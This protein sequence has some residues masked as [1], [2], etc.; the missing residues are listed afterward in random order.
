MATRY[1]FV[2]LI[3]S[4]SYLPGALTLAAALRD[5]HPKPAV[6]PEVD[7]QTACLV[8][9]ETV[10]VSSI[11]LLRG[12]FDVVIGVEVIDDEDRKGLELLGR[13][14]LA[15]ALTKLHAFRLAQ[16]TKVIYLDSDVL[17]IRPISHLFN[18]EHEF[19]AV[20]DVGWPD[21]FNSGVMV[22][23][24]GEE[25]FKAITDL[26]KEKGSWDGADQGLLNEWRGSNWNRLSFTYNTTPTAAYTYA[27]AYERFG[28][29]ISAIH[30]IG[31]NKPWYSILSRPPGA[32]YSL[33]KQTEGERVYD[34]DSLVDRWYSVY[35]RHYRSDS[36]PTNPFEVQQYD[37][38]WNQDGDFGAGFRTTASFNLEELRKIAVNGW[39]RLSS[40]SINRSG[41]GEYLSMPLE[42]R[43][44]LMRPKKH[45]LHV[46]E[47]VVSADTTPK[48]AHID[49]DTPSTPRAR[50]PVQ[51]TTLPTPSPSQV[52]PA[53][54]RLPLSLPPSPFPPG[55]QQSQPQTKSGH[56]LVSPPQYGAP[57]S[58][59]FDEFD[60]HAADA[61]EPHW[62]H[63]PN[64]QHR[65]HISQRQRHSFH[66]ANRRQ[67]A[68]VGDE[69]FRPTNLLTVF[70]Q[71]DDDGQSSE[72]DGANREEPFMLRRR[73]HGAVSPT[74]VTWNPAV[75]PPPRT[76]PVLSSA[77]PE[78]YYPN[79]WDKVPSKV[80]DA[81]HHRYANVS[82]STSDS[83]SSTP[84]P[85]FELPIP[86]KIPEGLVREGHYLNVTGPTNGQENSPTPDRSKVAPIF[87]WEEKPR[88][89]PG[90]VF[91]S[92][93]T[94]P[95]GDFLVQK[96]GSPVIHFSGDLPGSLPGFGS[97]GSPPINIPVSL[98]YRN[99][100][101]VEPSIQKYASKLAR[102]E[103]NAPRGSLLFQNEEWKQHEKDKFSPWQPKEEETSMDG[104]DE[105]DSDDAGPPRHS[106]Q[107]SR[108]G[109][110]TITPQ[111]SLFTYKGKYRGRGVQTESPEHRSKGVQIT[112][113][114]Q[115][116]EYPA[117]TSSPRVTS[118]SGNRSR[119]FSY[120]ESPFSSLHSRHVSTADSPPLVRSPHV[121]ISPRKYSPPLVNTPPFLSPKYS[122]VQTPRR[123]SDTSSPVRQRV[124][125][126]LTT[127]IRSV[128]ALAR[129]ASN[130][131]ALS[132]SV[133]PPSPD[134]AST[135]VRSTR[136]WDPA[137]GVDIFKKGSEE[138]L[139]RFLRMGSFED[140]S[141]TPPQSR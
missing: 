139:S 43:I 135:P 79:I 27:P 138:V 58:D 118:L 125:S 92:T 45:S 77:L 134:I 19:S 84:G 32:L 109:S 117:H 36:I 17:P 99:A 70:N 71:A 14:D 102:P 26:L 9:P 46:P 55:S 16:F 83:G 47:I 7:F 140:G 38:I 104:D 4:D 8:T 121:L 110:G 22:F 12:A 52:P 21:I 78:T 103:Q 68:G 64:R 87:P 95:P 75:E 24:P 13:P 141:A 72:G 136:V 51:M 40:T 73:R 2:T 56:F 39:S 1:A 123:R 66:D 44:D 74:V 122:P 88:I 11:K 6:K 86:A 18:L 116:G 132:S 91:P 119:R 37:S 69:N 126:P 89:V 67:D 65:H 25:K 98:T 81:I 60:T 10:D 63:H 107:R 129:S 30:F 59:Q 112:P 35:D 108:A 80:H 111:G 131:T 76:R 137:R 93:D 105:D 62:P 20:P 127:S 82:V 90:R 23:S 5:I 130:E 48:P 106:R 50:S 53:P 115:P 85:F 49:L 94:P 61:H 97:H 114:T 15:A 34:Y 96:P 42:G 31:T 28:P 57:D 101:D 54:H 113:M 3:T 29:Q 124:L 120:G 133:G 33:N 41:E 100:W 128:P